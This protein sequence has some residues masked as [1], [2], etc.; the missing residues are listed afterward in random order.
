MDLVLEVERVCGARL[1]SKLR[2]R[3]RVPTGCDG[4]DAALGGG[5]GRGMLTELFGGPASG[6][7][8][9]ALS[10]CASA[11]STGAA[12]VYVD[13]DGTFLPERARELVDAR[14]L[15]ES[16]VSGKSNPC[17][18]EALDR[19]LLFRVCSFDEL[20]AGFAHVGPELVHDRGDVHIVVVDSVSQ[21]F[22]T[23]EIQGAQKRLDSFAGRMA[24]LAMRYDVAVVLINNARI[25]DS[26]TPSVDRLPVGVA[27]EVGIPA[28]G[29]AWAHVCPC[30]VGF[31]RNRDGER[32]A[33][34]VKDSRMPRTSLNFQI[35]SR[36]IEDSS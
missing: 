26:P 19:W 18:E 17:T 8:Q 25:V 3:G 35:T 10:A 23:F 20:A 5:F 1:A 13:A 21:P 28:M 30:R 9:A 34:V 32:V 7:T 6:R 12:A 15:P 24:K 16:N 22:R 4:L 31:G 29:D 11:V 14:R 33:H 36:G 27:K 2:P